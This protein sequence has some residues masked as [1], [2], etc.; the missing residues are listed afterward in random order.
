M[1]NTT[2]RFGAF[3]LALLLLLGLSSCGKKKITDESKKGPTAEELAAKAAADSAAAAAKALQDSLAAVA[4]AEAEAKAKADEE[5]RMAAQKKAE[6]LA[7]ALSS[8][9][10]IYF[11][12]DKYAL[13]NDSRSSLE[14]NA[15]VMK[16]NGELTVLIEG[17]CDE[18]GSDSYNF[19]LGDK[20][21]NAAKEYLVNMGVAESNLRT[22]SYGKSR[23]AVEGSTEDAWSKNRRCEFTSGK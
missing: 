3:A 20:R 13:R 8:L 9:K 22:I 6:A 7:Q 10:T 11:D 15:G 18:N 19:A 17:H 16:A 1:K 21:A 12:F 23:P 14:G 4:R 2:I 5:A